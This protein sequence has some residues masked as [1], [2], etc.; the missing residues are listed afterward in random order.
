MTTVPPGQPPLSGT[1]VLINPFRVP[2]EERERFLANHKATMERLR[3][4]DGFL[5]GGLHELLQPVH[6]EAFDYVNVNHWRSIEAFRAG[7]AAAGPDGVFG[8]QVARLEAHPGLSRV[9]AAY[10][11]WAVPPAGDAAAD[12]LAIMDV[13]SRFETTFDRGELD[14]HM[15]FWGET[16]AF[17][18]PYMGDFRD[19]AGYREALRRFYDDL[20]GKG[21]TRHLMTNFEVD[22][23]GDRAQVRSY[24][25]V[26]NRASGAMLGVVEWRDEMARTAAGWRYLR[27]AQVA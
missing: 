22:L 15:A 16:L 6:A 3:L 1:V 17:E 24:L 27:R 11:S 13:A 26:F 19:H 14:E 25:T 8:D 20:Q 21:G 4:Q 10:G 5:G 7:I 18:S 12:R 23:S 2:E 9:A